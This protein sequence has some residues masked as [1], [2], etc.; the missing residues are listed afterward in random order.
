MLLTEHFCPFIKNIAQLL[1]T[2]LYSNHLGDS[3]IGTTSTRRKKAIARLGYVQRSTLG[4]LSPM[5][6][7]V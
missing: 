6:V 2:Q 3:A 1:L 7:H 4:A 5:T